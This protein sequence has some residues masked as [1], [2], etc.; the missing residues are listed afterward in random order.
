MDKT[1]KET[2]PKWKFSL[3]IR[4]EIPDE[5][6]K[7]FTAFKDIKSIDRI[8]A[9]A[10]LGFAL[11]IFMFGLDIYRQR[12]GEFYTS[13]WYTVLFYFHLLGLLFL[14]PAVY[15]TVYKKWIIQTRL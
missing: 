2:K 10:W 14:F 11:T 13:H 8:Q 7:E 5:L 1:Q 3:N 6:E 4:K 9:S 12:T 15:T